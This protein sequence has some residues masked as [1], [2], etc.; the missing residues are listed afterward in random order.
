M[1][2]S[3]EDKSEDSSDASFALEP[4]RTRRYHRCFKVNLCLNI[5][6]LVTFVCLITFGPWYSMVYQDDSKKLSA[7]FSLILLYTTVNDKTTGQSQF[8]RYW[9][10]EFPSLCDSCTS[11]VEPDS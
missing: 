8:N 9:A 5:S 1:I 4:G 6:M 11:Q 3:S 7:D 10:L 2:W